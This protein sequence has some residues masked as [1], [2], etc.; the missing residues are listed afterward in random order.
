MSESKTHTITLKGAQ[1]E[2]WLVL[3]GASLD[4]LEATLLQSF[5]DLDPSL[6]LPELIWRAQ[7]M[8]AAIRAV[9]VGGLVGDRE[10]AAT[11]P[12]VTYTHGASAPQNSAY[13]PSGPPQGPVP[14]CAHGPRQWVN[15]ANKPWKG[16]FCP[17][18]KDS[19]QTKCKPQFV[20]D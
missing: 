14:A 13:D 18:P 1:N 9:V 20:N 4:E 16:W 19:N 5:P 2:P 10:A 3:G 8:W 17:L 11:T 7:A 12:T 15:P 6:E